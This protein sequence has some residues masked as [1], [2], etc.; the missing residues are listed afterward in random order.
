MI[1]R[2]TLLFL[3]CLG[4]LSV[5]VVPVKGAASA[6]RIAH[7]ASA[8]LMIAQADESSASNVLSIGDQGQA[9]TALQERLQNTEQYDGPVDGIYGLAT[10]RAVLSFQEKKGFEPTGRLD[11]A[12]WEALQSL[13]T[14]ESQTVAA[15]SDDAQTSA[16]AADLPP[17]GDSSGD[18]GDVGDAAA[19]SADE[20]ANGY[21]KFLGLGLGLAAL[22]ASFGVGFFIANRSKLE[23]EADADETWGAVG[24]QS[25]AASGVDSIVLPIDERAQSATATPSLGGSNALA[26]IATPMQNGQLGGTSALGPTEVVDS[27][28]KDLHNPDPGQRRK[29]IWEL[30]QRGSSLAVQPLVDAM[31]SADSKEKSLVLAALSEIGQRSLKPMNRALA[32]ALQDENPEVRKNAI[33]DIT[34]VYELV[35]Q[36]SQMLGHA[37]EDEDAEVRQT[38]TWALDQLNRLRRT[39]DI[40]T[41]M[42]SFTAGNG[43]NRFAS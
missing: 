21:G 16:P 12:T 20:G 31:V 4:A 2:S 11:D 40:D 43:P 24:V 26:A 29:I 37:T 6:N 27:L 18:A 7:S 8:P 42:R 1:R 39:Q 14:S 41:N 15:V 34:R 28:I 17:V 22:V 35:I 32:L 36:I 3:T 33:R 13:E 25:G 30:G 10:Q 23:A 5:S 38:A 19:V 9:V